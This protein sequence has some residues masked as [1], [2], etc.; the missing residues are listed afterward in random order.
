L[1]DDPSQVIARSGEGVL[2][3]QDTIYK[4]ESEA[5]GGDGEEAPNAGR[6]LQDESDQIGNSPLIDGM[7]T[8]EVK[9]VVS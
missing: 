1:F 9:D 4:D 5:Q 7:K 6:T 8:E 3:Y 2:K